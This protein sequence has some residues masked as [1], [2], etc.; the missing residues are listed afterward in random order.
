MQ[1]VLKILHEITGIPPGTPDLQCCLISVAAPC[2]M[3]LIAGENLPEPG[4]DV[5]RIDRRI[6]AKHL[7][8]FA[9]AGLH[10]AGQEYQ[11]RNKETHAHSLAQN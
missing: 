7:L 4:R 8:R 9:L 10:A 1:V 11:S 5:L 3:F 2:A 6:L